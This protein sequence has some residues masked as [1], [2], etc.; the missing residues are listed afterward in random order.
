MKTKVEVLLRE[1]VAAIGKCG[2]VVR[3]ASGYARNY[4]LPRKLAVEANEDNKRAM[5]RRRVKL[6]LE[7]AQ[8]KAAVDARVAALLGVVLRTSGKADAE[9]HLFG[10]VNAAQIVELLKG[11]GHAFVEKDIRM[12]APL[13]TV[14]SHVVR[15]HVHGETHAEIRIEVAPESSSA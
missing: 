1:N 10:S 6:D 11:Q 13:K 4:L 12:D 8:A 14:G 5:L 9:G 7:E 15:V 3:V 2:D